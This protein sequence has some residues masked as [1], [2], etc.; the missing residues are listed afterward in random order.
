MHCCKKKRRKRDVKLSPRIKT[1]ECVNNNNNNNLYSFYN[2]IQSKLKHSFKEKSTLN[3]LHINLHI[4]IYS[5]HL[6]CIVSYITH[7]A[8]LKAVQCDSALYRQQCGNTL[9][10][11]PVQIFHLLI[12][13]QYCR[14]LVLAEPGFCWDFFSL[15]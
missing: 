11:K 14:C 12:K 7:N 2:L 5:L 6:C 4:W 8:V 15:Q 10:L 13:H 3:S 9:I 1:L